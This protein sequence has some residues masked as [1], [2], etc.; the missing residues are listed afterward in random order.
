MASIDDVPDDLKGLAR[1]VAPL[2]RST[3]TPVELN[4]RCEFAAQLVGLAALSDEG[5]ARQLRRKARQHLEALSAH[6]LGE[7]TAHYK[8]LAREAALNNDE[9]TADSWLD[10]A[11]DLVRRNPQLP[12]DWLRE[13]QVVEVVRSVNRS[14]ANRPRW[15]PFRRNR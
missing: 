15:S 12:E 13:V 10:E 3:M 8:E 9:R 7:Q 2:T 4:L 5:E 11:S 14:A 1:V 6:S